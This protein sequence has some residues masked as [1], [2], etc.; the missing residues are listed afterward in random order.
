MIWKAPAAK[1]DSTTSGQFSEP[2]AMDRTHS[3]VCL[4]RFLQYSPGWPG[5]RFVDQASLE[6][7]EIHLPLSPKC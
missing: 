2:Q 5:T 6:L 3:F 4:T 7:I 1:P